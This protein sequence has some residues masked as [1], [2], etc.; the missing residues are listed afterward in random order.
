[1]ITRL[2]LPAVTVA[3]IVMQ[4]S[5][6]KADIV[7]GSGGSSISFVAH[8]GFGQSFTASLSES[9]LSSV[10]FR[11]ASF[12]AAQPDPT[13]TVQVHSG[14][15]YD[16]P[17]LATQTVAAIPDSTPNGAWIDF[18]FDVPPLLLP[19]SMYTLQFTQDTSGF[20]SG[21]YQSA[22]LD[23]YDGGMFFT[24]GGSGN[25]SVDLAFRVESALPV[26]VPEAGAWIFGVLAAAVAGMP[27]RVRRERTRR[28]TIA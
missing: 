14:E 24:S 23:V 25:P 28:P 26:S 10:S 16:G 21:G 12:N 19:G 8:R 5:A 6:A 2:F 13:I 9:V 22:G 15:G 4:L 1:M 18:G 3:L 27:V 17:V 7:Q 11:W 20:V